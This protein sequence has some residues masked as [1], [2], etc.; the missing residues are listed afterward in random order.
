MSTD[1]EF[2]DITELKLRCSSGIYDVFSIHISRTIGAY[3]VCV[4]TLSEG[5]DI[6]GTSS[7]PELDE[8]AYVY[9]NTKEADN[10]YMYPLFN[11]FVVSETTQTTIAPNVVQGYRSYRLACNTERLSSI[12]PLTSTWVSN[13][14]GKDSNMF[15]SGYELS[16][17]KI[18]NINAAL[19]ELRTTANGDVGNSL[20]E[21]LTS[22]QQSLSESADLVK[23]CIQSDTIQFN[24]KNSTAFPDKLTELLN[25]ALYSGCD[26]YTA[27]RQVV[28]AMGLQLIP[29]FDMVNETIGDCMCICNK[30]A[31]IKGNLT[32][33]Q[34]SDYSSIHNSSVSMTHKNVD[35][36][37]IPLS[38]QHMSTKNPHSFVIYGQLGAKGGTPKVITRESL[39]T[40]S[41]NNAEPLHLNVELMQLPAWLWSVV[42]LPLNV[43]TIDESETVDDI[44]KKL[45]MTGFAT[46]AYQQSTTTVTIPFQIYQ[47]MIN[48]LG[49]N[50][51]IQILQPGSGNITSRKQKYVCGR[52]NSLSVRI[53]I[54][55]SKL[56]VSANASFTHVAPEEVYN[57]Y[58]VDRKSLLFI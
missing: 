35:G 12:P 30:P 55:Q 52:L 7:F 2:T 9:M 17:T 20:L 37:V 58:A 51:K 50:Y 15:T 32:P 28:G 3:P 49:D 42:P 38:T 41:S 57:E 43:K 47:K 36:V 45:A 1:F 44:A 34:L 56:E 54:L 26:Y 48:T 22:F 18:T 11:G 39:T 4:V 16:K 8:A 5:S 46:R 33:L 53:N 10:E 25:T 19:N 40:E 6:D 29:Y 14:M 31:W 24:V 27:V 13:A 23:R 21:I